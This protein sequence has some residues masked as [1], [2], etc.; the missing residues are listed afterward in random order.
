MPLHLRLQLLFLNVALVVAS[1]VDAPTARPML[2]QLA[3]L[4]GTWSFEAR[5]RVVTEQWMAPAGGTMLGMSRTVSGDRTIAHEFVLLREDPNGDIHY[6]A[7][8]SG[9]APASFKLVHLADAEVIFENPAHDFPQRIIYRRT[10][11]GG[12]MAAIEGMRNGEPRRIEFHYQRV[13]P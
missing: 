12:L 6:E 13:T 8:P 5:G 10:E 11:G 4:A 3:W 9:Q 1:A 2:N 7:R